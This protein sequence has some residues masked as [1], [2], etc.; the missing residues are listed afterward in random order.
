MIVIF[1]TVAKNEESY[2]ALAEENE[3]NRNLG[4][5]EKK[6]PMDDI[7]V[8]IGIECDDIVEFDE[9]MVTINGKE[10]PSIS[11]KKKDGSYSPSFFST[12]G[13]FIEI[14]R[15]VRPELVIK[16]KEEILNG[17]FKKDNQ[18]IT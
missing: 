11:C 10:V 6:S 9:G 8:P 17:N 14:L 2:L 4:I 18:D 7:E 13:E 15:I 5:P 1:K 16:T 3:K 12:L